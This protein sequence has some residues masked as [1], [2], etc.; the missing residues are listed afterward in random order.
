M[1]NTNPNDVPAVTEVGNSGEETIFV[2]SPAHQA[3]RA[4]TKFDPE[5]VTDRL[6]ALEAEKDRR[7]AQDLQHP[8]NS[9]KDLVSTLDPIELQHLRDKTGQLYNNSGPGN[10]FLEKAI[11]AVWEEH[12]LNHQ[13]LPDKDD[14]FIVWFSKTLGN[15]KALVG[16]K[17]STNYFEVTF[18]GAKNRAYVDRYSKLSNTVVDGNVL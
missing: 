9:L 12:Y 6:E 8:E 18:D 3:Q 1:D 5:F 7:E 4:G 13:S 15:W 14:L 2:E 17:S 16:Q 11:R 10:E